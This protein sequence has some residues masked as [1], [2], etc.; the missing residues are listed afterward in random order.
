MDLESS[1]FWVTIGGIGLSVLKPF[2]LG[3]EGSWCY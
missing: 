1:L 3:K 2:F